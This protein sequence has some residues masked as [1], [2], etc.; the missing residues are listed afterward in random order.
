MPFAYAAESDV[1]IVAPALAA[2]HVGGRLHARHDDRL[3]R[4]DPLE[5]PE[6]VALV[7]RSRRLGADPRVTNFGGGNTSAKVELEDPITGEPRHVLAVKGSGGDL[8]T[9]TPG[10]ARARRPRAAARDG[11]RL[12]GARPRG[13]DGRAARPRPLRAG[14]RGAVDRHAAARI[15]PGRARRPSPSRRADRVR[16]RRGRAASTSPTLSAG[17]LGWLDWQRP[18][19][20]LGLRLRDLVAAQPELVGVVLGGHGV[21]SWAET[22]DDVRRR[23]RCR[24]IEQAERYLAEHGRPEPF[25]RRASGFARA[26]R[27]TERRR[28]AAALAPVVRGLAATDR[29][30]VGR[31]DRL[32]GRARLPRLGGGAA[33]RRARHLLPRPLPAHE[34]AAAAARPARRRLASRS[35]PHGCASCTR[36]TARSTAG[37]TRR[38]RRP[39]SPPMRGA[40]PAIVLVPGHRHVELRRRR[41]DGARRRRVLR[42]RDQRHARRRGALLVRAD[43]GLG[44]VPRRVLGARGAQAPPAP[45]RAAADRTRRL[46][47]RRGLRASASRSRSDCTASAPRSSLAD[48]ERGRG[49]S[50][51]RRRSPTRTASSRV[52]VDVTDE[53]VRR[54]GARAPTC[55]RFGGVDIVV[56]NAGLAQLRAAPRDRDRGLRPARTP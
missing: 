50:A 7:E 21:I 8:G 23:S 5:H 22:S 26:S 35:R 37:T 29:R 45:A 4:V 32:R 48:L 38:T 2:R 25:G 1:P 46:R 53:A 20:D 33:A 6:I 28:R 13:R 16:D 49:A 15:S 56:N 14:R 54:R 11:A 30:V 31:F 36:S 27:R 17:R 42:Q 19:F 43:P 41:A 24:S 9:L 18:G 55:L 47:H 39:D 12:R 40:D 51:R 10:R 34:G 44:E 52:A 3:W